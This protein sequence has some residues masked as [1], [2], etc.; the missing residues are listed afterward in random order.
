MCRVLCVSRS[1]YYS[2]LRRPP[3][4]RSIENERLVARIRVIHAQSRETYGSPRVH[5]E[6]VSEGERVNKKRVARLMR[7]NGIQ[8]KTARRFK[9]TTN[10]NHSQP[11]AENTLNREFYATAPN[12][13][14]L[15]DITYIWTCEGWLYLAVVLDLFAKRVV[16]WSMKKTLSRALVFGGLKMAV[17]RRNPDRNLLHHSDRGSQ[18]ASDDYQLLLGFYDMECSMSRKGDC[19]DNAPM[20]SFFATLKKELVYTTIFQTRQ[21]AIDAVFDFIECFYNTKRRHSANGQVS[22]MEFERMYEMAAAV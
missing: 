8:P 4:E 14:W 22:P 9:V 3:S 12:R 7:E 16:G 20:E 2:W 1:G 6:L 19:W 15:T 13:K 10:S 21:E 11:V 18:Y 5:A 17:G